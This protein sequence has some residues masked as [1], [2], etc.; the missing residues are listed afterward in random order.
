MELVIDI[1]AWVSLEAE[2]EMRILLQVVW[3]VIPG[4]RREGARRK[5]Q[6]RDAFLKLLL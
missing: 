1:L 3:E 6:S 2:P 4:S 5:R